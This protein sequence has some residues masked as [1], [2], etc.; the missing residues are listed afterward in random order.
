MAALPVESARKLVVIPEKALN[1]LNI[2]MYSFQNQRSMAH[3]H[4]IDFLTFVDGQLHP[5]LAKLEHHFTTNRNATITEAETLCKDFIQ[6]FEELKAFC[7]QA[8]YSGSPTG[9][10]GLVGYNSTL[11][12]F[13]VQPEG[14]RYFPK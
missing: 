2:R 4:K 14:F 3:I 13:E 12:T 1:V 6:A 11:D 8:N 9:Y 5:D 10:D 7:K